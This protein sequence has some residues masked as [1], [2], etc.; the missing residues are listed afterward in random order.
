LS[1]TNP[2]FQG[3]QLTEIQAAVIIH[4]LAHAAGV[5]KSDSGNQSQSQQNSQDVYDA[6]FKGKH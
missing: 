4:E 3:L 2:A 5:I 6:C 1:S